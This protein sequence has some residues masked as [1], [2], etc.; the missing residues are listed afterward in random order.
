VIGWTTALIR[1]AA[2]SVQAA[3]AASSVRRTRAAPIDIRP[4]IFR[5]LHAD[6]AALSGSRESA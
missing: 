1:R 6:L 3:V 4:L 5:F 2:V